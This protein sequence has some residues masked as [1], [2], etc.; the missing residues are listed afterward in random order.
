MPLDIND[1][2]KYTLAKSFT[3]LAIQNDLFFKSKNPAETAK[4]I[5]T[6]FDTIVESIGSTSN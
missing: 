2:G 3:E 6:F 4:D 1:N 5:A